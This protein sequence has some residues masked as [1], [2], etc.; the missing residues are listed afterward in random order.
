MRLMNSSI[1]KNLD[2][3]IYMAKKIGVKYD[4]FNNEIINYDE[5]F[6]LGKFN[7]QP[8]SG[9]DLQAYISA[10]GE[11]KNKLIRAFLDVKFRNKIK[12]FDLAYLYN[13]TPKGEKINGVNA[14]YYVRTCVEQNTVIMVVF[15]EIIKEE[16]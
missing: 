5:P 9:N 16:N 6:Y 10:Y 1:Y 4:E 8:L 13:A 3:K 14:N 7:Y 12:E 2:K 15:E 11:T